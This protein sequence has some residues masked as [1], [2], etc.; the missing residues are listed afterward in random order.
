MNADGTYESTLSSPSAPDTQDD[1]TYTQDGSQ[2]GFDSN[3]T[4][5]FDGSAGIDTIE[6]SIPIPNASP[7]ELSWSK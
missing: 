2:L 6:M 5:P 1:G 3:V 7:I 4:G